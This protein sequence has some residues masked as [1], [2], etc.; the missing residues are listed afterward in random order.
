MN[1]S[2][3]GEMLYQSMFTAFSNAKYYFQGAKQNKRRGYTEEL[4][5]QKII[6]KAQSRLKQIKDH[7][8]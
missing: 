8:K 6:K 5:L 4:E 7:K 1:N 2:K 3:P